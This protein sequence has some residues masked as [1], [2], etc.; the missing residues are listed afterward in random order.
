MTHAYNESYLND[1][2]QNLGDMLDYA[3]NDLGYNGDD[4]F[5]WF[6]NSGIA[7]KF[8][9]GNPKYTV[10]KSGYELANDVIYKTTNKFV[11]K[12]PSKRYFDGR[13]F[14]CGWVLAYYQWY[15]GLT[16]YD[17]IYNGLTVSK[18]LSMYILH[19][20]DINKFVDAANKI[21]ED[22]KSSSTKL[23][24][25]R[26]SRNLTQ[27]QLAEISGVSLRMIQLYEQRENDINKASAIV[28]SKLSRTLG[29]E[30]DDLME[31]LL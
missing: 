27:K 7:K 31:M 12:T 11:N 25:I 23:Q 20:A 3:I 14:W 19:E 22:N 16:F 21:I 9:N 24:K 28:V 13:E 30:V 1:A 17:I 2:M 18:I 5:S 26:K 10:G 15:T 29:C 4:F 8:E 6:I